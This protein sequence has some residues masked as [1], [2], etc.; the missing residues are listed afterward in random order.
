[1]IPPGARV[2]FVGIGGAGMSAIASVL[3][4]RG[5]VISGSDLRES[6]ITRRLRAAG[7]QI[8]IGH[9]AEHVQPDQVVVIRGITKTVEVVPNRGNN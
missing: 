9:A 8:Q 4:A 2:H 6:E 3:M 7:A 5:Y 1:M